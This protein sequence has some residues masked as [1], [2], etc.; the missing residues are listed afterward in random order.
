MSFTRT[1]AFDIAELIRVF[2]YDKTNDKLVNTTESS[3]FAAVKRVQRANTDQFLLDSF[4]TDTVLAAKYVISMTKGTKDHT[5]EILV[6]HNTTNANMVE[7]AELGSDDLGTLSVSINGSTVELKCTPSE[8]NVQ[9]KFQ[10]T[11]VDA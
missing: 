6:S 11:T 3:K 9:I 8:A 2:K 7:Y 5:K 10:R 1:K 4:D